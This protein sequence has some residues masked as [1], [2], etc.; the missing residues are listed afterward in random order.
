MNDSWWQLGDN[1]NFRRSLLVACRFSD[2]CNHSAVNH[3]QRATIWREHAVWSHFIVVIGVDF[4]LSVKP[5]NG[6]SDSEPSAEFPSVSLINVMSCWGHNTT[7]R[8]MV[9]QVFSAS[10]GIIIQYINNR[11]SNF[12]SC[13]NVVVSSCPVISQHCNQFAASF[14]PSQSIRFIQL[15]CSNFC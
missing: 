3:A 13:P 2:P 14:L 10:H 6:Y 15:T 5:Q 11:Q 4:H 12:F 1:W 9:F 7:D 8:L